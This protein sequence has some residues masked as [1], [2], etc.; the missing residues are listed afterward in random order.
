MRDSLLQ[1]ELMNIPED[2]LRIN[3][4]GDHL[5][6]ERLRI[7]TLLTKVSHVCRKLEDLKAEN[8][9]LVNI[10]KELMTLETKLANCHQII[11][12]DISLSNTF[13]TFL[14]QD[15]EDESKMIR[16]MLEAIPLPKHRPVE[17][18]SSDRGPGVCSNERL[19]QIKMAETFQIYN[20]D[21][22]ARVHYAPN[23][24]PSHIAEK[25]MR[26]FNEQA[27]E[28][29]TINTP[30]VELTELEDI[31]GLVNMSKTEIEILKE[32]QQEL[33]SK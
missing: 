26:S 15:L 5:L 8:E 16:L 31:G 1:F 20:L 32:K 25:V 7:D 12:S 21:L 24:S 11:V 28:G 27:G 4:K 10:L 2:F 3:E 22:Q 30:E 14:Y 19:V 6:R 29:R 17:I 13:I 9:K 23:D 18:Q 33:A